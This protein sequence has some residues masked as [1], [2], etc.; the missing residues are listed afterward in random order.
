MLMLLGIDYCFYQNGSAAWYIGT[1]Q[2]GIPNLASGANQGA[3][4]AAAGE[5]WHDTT[6]DTIKMGV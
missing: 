1:S 3:S 6:D 4:G 2:F 5:L